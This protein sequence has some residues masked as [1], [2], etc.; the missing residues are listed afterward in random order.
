MNKR[1]YINI[2]DIASY[3]NQNKWGII[4]AFERL[5]KKSDDNYNI[6]INKLK[7][8]INESN[9]NLE[10][11]KEEKKELLDNLNEK[12][13]NKD[14]YDIELIKIN[15]K[16]DDINMDIIDTSEKVDNIVV[17]KYDK[18][19]NNLGE[20]MM[21]MIKDTS[22]NLKNKK[23]EIN[24]FI[25]KLDLKEEKKIK[26]INDTESLM[27]TT[28]GLN[29]EKTAIELFEERYNTKL[30][31]TQKYYCNIVKKTKNKIW[32]IGG[33]LD[34]INEEY[35]VEIKN[36]TNRFFNV[37]REYELTQIQLYL[38]LTN[39]KNGK[40]V[41]KFKNNIKVIDIEYDKDYVRKILEYLN[42]V[43]DKMEEFI[44]ND[45]LKEEYINMLNEDEKIRFI[46][47]L[48]INDVIK[49]INEYENIK[50]PSDLDTDEL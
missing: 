10:E 15:K 22:I 50:Y 35:I 9:K 3:I 41:E 13:I 16:E 20:N 47:K 29:M 46:Y 28:Y 1:I 40:L 6:Q 2:S 37:I 49:K 31:T 43:I 5:W 7:E 44:K 45:E 17:S 33:K 12:K 25:E 18:V 8:I 48:Y 30:D 27:K 14:L 21:N 23:K 36:R 39:M 24:N 32:Y 38:Y 11:I 42:I 4:D 19:K 34:G 26:L